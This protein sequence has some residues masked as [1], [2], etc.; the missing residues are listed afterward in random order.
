MKG[1]RQKSEKEKKTAGDRTEGAG[2]LQSLLMAVAL[3]VSL[4][5]INIHWE[6]SPI[7]TYTQKLS[8]SF[9]LIPPRTP[10]VSHGFQLK[11]LTWKPANHLILVL[12]F[13]FPKWYSTAFKTVYQTWLFEETPC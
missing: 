6:K 4:L 12:F 9:S 8:L 13:Y 7:I 1:E 3:V 11:K 2:L 10:S 5:Y